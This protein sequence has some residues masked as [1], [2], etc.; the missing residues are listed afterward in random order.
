M[1]QPSL[2]SI[3]AALDY[4]EIRVTTPGNRKQ[5]PRVLCIV[6]AAST[7]D[8]IHVGRL[9]A[10]QPVRHIGAVWIGLAGYRHG[11]RHAGFDV[12]L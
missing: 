6:Q 11:L 2:P 8:A 5:A 7:A 9:Y 12:S 3:V 4:Y 1:T 10:A